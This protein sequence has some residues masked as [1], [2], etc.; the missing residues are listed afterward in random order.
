[1]RKLQGRA[2]TRLIGAGLTAAATAAAMVAMAPAAYA[3]DVQDTEHDFQT[4]EAIVV[5]GGV[6]LAGGAL[7][8]GLI[9]LATHKWNRRY[10]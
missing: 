8:G 10:P 1:M 6:G 9:G 4:G 5:A 3:A 2:R 7:L